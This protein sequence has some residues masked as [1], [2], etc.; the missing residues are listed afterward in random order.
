MNCPKCGKELDKSWQKKYCSRSCANSVANSFSPKRKPEGSCRECKKVI[1]TR[2]NYCSPE[3]KKTFTERNR[4]IARKR[5]SKAAGIAV[6]AYRRRIKEKA[7]IYKG[8]KCQKCGY[9]KCIRAL[10]F[11]HLLGKDFSISDGGTKSWEIV[12]TEI[13]KCELV[14]AN[15][16]A[17]IHD[18]KFKNAGGV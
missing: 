15:C 1:S 2:F 16:H 9:D 11:H 4:N 8:G 12:K 14:C 13:D 5:R 6:I 3:C 17:E 10:Q 7:V 18:A